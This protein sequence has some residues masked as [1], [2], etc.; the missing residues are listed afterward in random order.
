MVKPK[1]ISARWPFENLQT[2]GMSRPSMTCYRR[3]S[4]QALLHAPVFLNWISHHDSQNANDPVAPAPHDRCR[5]KKPPAGCLACGLKAL[6]AVYWKPSRDSRQINTSALAIDQT[7]HTL[8]SR[9][10]FKLS[11]RSIHE[12]G[13]PMEFINWILSYFDTFTPPP[14]PYVLHSILTMC[15][16]F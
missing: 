5:S 2:T 14:M 8:G 15:T 13:D 3:S 10:N 1:K 9:P 7:I 12:Q 16:S 11:T 4:L 6:A